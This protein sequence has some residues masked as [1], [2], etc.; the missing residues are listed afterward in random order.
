MFQLLQSQSFWETFLETNSNRPNREGSKSEKKY[1]DS[2]A[3]LDYK[4]PDSPYGRI[5]NVLGTER[6]KSRRFRWN[7]DVWLEDGNLLVLKGGVLNP[8]KKFNI[9]KHE[10]Q[11]FSSLLNRVDNDSVMF[12]PS[13][14]LIPRHQEAMNRRNDRNRG[15]VVSSNH[16]HD[17][18]INSDNDRATNINHYN[19]NSNNNMF[20]PVDFHC[21][22]C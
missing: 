6:R 11:K 22:I 13:K 7:K 3:Y 12:E 2:D 17:N 21:F 4:S 10:K 8:D 19:Y 15:F 20:W 14:R 16:R 18:T 5:H 1:E 9:K